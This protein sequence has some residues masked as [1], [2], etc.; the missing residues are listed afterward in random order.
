MNNCW[1]LYI[2]VALTLLAA[3][4]SKSNG[5]DEPSAGGSAQVTFAVRAPQ[6]APE[7]PINAHEMIN[8][9]WMAFVAS[10]GTVE[11]ILE[12]EP[13]RTEPV[14]Q[15]YT[16]DEMPLGT[17]DVYAFANI[18]PDELYAASGIRFTPGAKVS[19]G[20]TAARWNNMVN[21]W[22]KDTHIPMTGHQRVTVS[23]AVHQS[24]S[25]EVVR[26]VGKVTFEFTSNSNL[27]IAVDYVTMSPMTD[28][29][30]PLLP[31]YST[32]GTVQNPAEG[33]AT[34]TFCYDM[35][36]LHVAAG[37]QDPVSDYFYVRETSAH[38]HPTGRFAIGVGITRAGNSSEVQ[39]A[40][41]DELTYINRNDHVVIPVVFS[42]FH[43]ELDVLFYPPIGGYPAV[44][45]EENNAEHYVIFGTQ[46]LFAITPRVF[47]VEDSPGFNGNIDP[48]RI[49]IELVDISDPDGIFRDRPDFDSVT[50][51]I[52]GYMSA[53]VISGRA[54][55]SLRISVKV[56]D[57]VSRVYNR[58][59]YILR[60]QS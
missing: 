45:V 57:T 50:G 2:A 35:G 47:E 55:V 59:V 26:L 19:D 24:F 6:G 16:F 51:E 42:E 18:T 29:P 12:R 33:P 44:I 21:N 28:G 53:D 46:G 9:W 39:Y 3:S 4:C 7:D 5:S 56:S 14:E 32:L 34:G 11:H 22:P 52:T 30:V 41:A 36:G 49:K 60:Q 37:T 17:Y 13:E 10:D 40:L 20:I 27:D 38:N 15:E 54:T 43:F 1:T 25:I 23:Q 31:D 58:T 8:S 48:D